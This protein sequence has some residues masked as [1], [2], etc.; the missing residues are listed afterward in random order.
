MARPE[1]EYLH[2]LIVRLTHGVNFAA[3]GIMVLSG[4]RI[5]NASPIWEFKIPDNLTLGGWLAGARMWH[6]FGMGL[7]FVNGIVWYCKTS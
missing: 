6:F 1:K 7:F 2:P 4:F 5:Y 3:L